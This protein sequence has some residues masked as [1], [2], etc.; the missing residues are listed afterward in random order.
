VTA[1]RA[2]TSSRRSRS[3]TRRRTLRCGIEAPDL[4]FKI[5]V[6][7]RWPT[8][9]RRRRDDG[10][11]LRAVPR[12]PR[13]SATHRGARVAL[14]DARGKRTD[15]LLWGAQDGPFHHD[16]GRRRFELELRRERYPLPFALKLADFRKEDHPR[17]NMPKS[18]ESD[19]AVKSAGSERALT[20]SMNEPLRADGLVVLPGSWGPQKRRRRRA[21]L[22][23][24]RGRAQPGRFDAADRLHRDRGGSLHA[25]RAQAGAPRPHRAR[26]RVSAILSR[27]SSG[28][29]LTGRAR[30]RRADRAGFPPV[31]RAA[32][33]EPAACR[34]AAA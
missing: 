21:A 2:S 28:T 16:D 12:E 4:P 33:R 26:T 13:P 27:C 19:V 14:V 5:E 34:T 18:F 6:T 7:S 24:V 1:P 10:V 22:L 11:Q 17:S 15:G 8:R 3:R 30:G 9:G 23:D 25:L 20:I 29:A 31:R 32:L